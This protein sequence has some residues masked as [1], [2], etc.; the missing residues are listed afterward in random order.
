[1]RKRLFRSGFTLVELLVVI[2][3]I[4]VLVA[5]LLPAVQAARE[6]A[7]RTQCSNH[8]KQ[9]SLACLQHQSQLGFYP[10]GGW[11]P[12]WVGDA[13]CGS[14]KMQPGGWI[15][16]ILPFIEEGPLYSLYDPKLPNAAS[17]PNMNACRQTRVKLYVCPVDTGP[18]VP[19]NPDSGPGGNTGLV[20]PDYMPGSYRA[21]SWA[22]YGFQNLHTGSGDAY[23][24]DAGQVSYLMGWRSDFRGPMHAVLHRAADLLLR[25][26]DRHGVPSEPLVARA[27]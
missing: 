3:I 15:Y 18:F 19:A 21:V 4:G 6:A 26:V 17:T 23:W 22:T 20:R 7:R 16:R 14:G 1:M 13:D 12:W 10:G 2:A 9:M 5:L 8:V 11:G 25:V 27:G 24:D